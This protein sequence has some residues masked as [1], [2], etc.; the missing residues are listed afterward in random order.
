MLGRQMD[1]NQVPNALVD[2]TLV[3]EANVAAHSPNF[4]GPTLH[5]V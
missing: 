1:K 5:E 3:V 2:A 4:D